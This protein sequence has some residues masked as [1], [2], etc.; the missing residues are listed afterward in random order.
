VKIAQFHDKGRIKLG[1]V[2]ADSIMP[3]DFDG[4]MVSFISSGRRPK[5][6]GNSLSIDAVSL[7]PPVTRPSKIIAIGLNYKD[8]AEE[9]KG[10]CQM[11]PWF[12]PS[13]QIV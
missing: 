13:F 9:S 5:L 10:T 7:A 3:I 6:S 1:L 12:L 11:S 8:H 2:Q 4:D